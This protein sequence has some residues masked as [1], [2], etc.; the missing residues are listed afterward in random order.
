MKITSVDIFECNTPNPLLDPLFVRVNTDAGISGFGEIGLAYGKSKYGGL[1]QARDLAQLMIGWDPMNNEGIWEMFK[2]NTFWGQ[3]GQ[4]GG[5]VFS[6]AVSALDIA[7]WD[8][9]GKVLGV[10]CYQLLGGKTNERIRAY[11]SQ[12]QF[13]WD[14]VHRNI[15]DPKDYAEAVKKA[16]AQ[17]YTAVKVDPVCVKP[18]GVYARE[19]KPDPNWRTKGAL[20]GEVINLAYERVKVMREAGGPNL[21]IILELHAFTDTSTAIRLGQKLEELDIYYMEEPTDPTNAECMREIREKVNIPVASGERISSRWGFREFLEKRA[22]QVI[23]PDLCVAGGFTE[24]KKICDM[25]NVYDAGVQIHVCGGPIAT[26]ATLQLEAAIPNFLIHELHE[27]ALKKEI[28]E[29]CKYDHMP[30]EGSYIVPDLPGIGNELT[31]KA[32]REAVSMTIK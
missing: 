11:A 19:P 14:E 13:D 20:S 17:G 10:P 9:K 3:G 1:G 16:M 22:L 18:D 23:Q 26:A 30:E 4:C 21:D 29:L 6:A 7:V 2:R 8:I 15:S 24:V 31:E 12:L 27:G 32:M 25:A 5:I 28:R